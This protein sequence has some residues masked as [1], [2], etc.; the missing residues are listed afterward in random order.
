MTGIG[1]ASGHFEI[2]SLY[3]RVQTTLNVY[4]RKVCRVHIYPDGENRDKNPAF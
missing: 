4:V 1:I 3:E 2:E